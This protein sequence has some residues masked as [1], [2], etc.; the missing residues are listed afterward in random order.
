MPDSG[1]TGETG[2]KSATGETDS[3]SRFEIRSSRFSEL[4]IGPFSHVTR[5]SLLSLVTRHLQGRIRKILAE[6]CGE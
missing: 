6:W 5:V 3:G 2:G 1:E 4:R